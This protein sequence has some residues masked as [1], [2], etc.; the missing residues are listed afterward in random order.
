MA[1]VKTLG[2]VRI[3][4]G[5]LC[6]DAALEVGEEEWPELVRTRREFCEKVVPR[7]CRLLLFFVKDAEDAGWLGYENRD[8]YLRDG[9]N[10]DP[11]LV[12]WALRGLE[13]TRPDEAVALADAVVLG[14]HGA[15]PGNKNA[16]KQKE[17]NK[18]GRSTFEF[19]KNTKVHWIA[20][21]DRDRP[22][23]AARVRSGELK[24]KTA[25]REA[26]IIKRKG[27]KKMLRRFELFDG[28]GDVFIEITRIDRVVSD[29]DAGC[30]TVINNQEPIRIRAT[31]KAKA[32]LGIMEAPK[33]AT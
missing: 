25:A 19:G 32:D 12:Q 18:G 16:A 3:R 8:S 33:R 1:A 9:L 26:G 21:L 23:L 4:G 17:Q 24:A 15:P 29:N 7:D 30:L 20:R 6:G 11:E 28:S 2:S 31:D 5:T 10:L 27:E 22:D 14:K 13:K